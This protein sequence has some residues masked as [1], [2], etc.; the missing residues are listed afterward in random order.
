MFTA[1]NFIWSKC[2]WIWYGLNF[3]L[4]LI[5]NLNKLDKPPPPWINGPL[6]KNQNVLYFKLFLRLK[7]MIR[8]LARKLPIVMVTYILNQALWQNF[9]TFFTLIKLRC[10]CLPTCYTYGWNKTINHYFLFLYLKKRLCVRLISIWA[11][12]MRIPVNYKK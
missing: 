3:Y 11:I 1:L 9:E 12:A 5:T 7:K 6:G 4:H 8:D 10:V 2:V